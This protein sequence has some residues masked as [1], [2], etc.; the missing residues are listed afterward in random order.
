MANAPERKAP[1]TIRDAAIMPGQWRNFAGRVTDFNKTGKREINIALPQ[2]VAE[3]IAA[4][5]LNVKSYENQDGDVTYRLK[6]FI[7][8]AIKTPQ[9][10]LI[11]GGQKTLLSEDLIGILD[12]ADIVKADLTIQPSYWDVN[13]RNGYSAYVSKAY[14]T[15]VQDELDEE[16]ANVPLAHTG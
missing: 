12:D 16:Y 1:I 11:S 4:D 9:I 15:I 14:I 10:Y 6:A 2:D 7:S 8:Y 5:G 13:G 3:A